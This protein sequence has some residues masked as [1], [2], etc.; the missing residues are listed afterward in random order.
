MLIIEVVGRVGLPLEFIF[1]A[2]ARLPF[3]KAVLRR[4]LGGVA[5]LY[6]LSGRLNQIGRAH[7]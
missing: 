7:V 6:A 4:S 1:E 3:S 5:L 2:N